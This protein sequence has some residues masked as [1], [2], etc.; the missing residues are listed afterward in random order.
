M[1]DDPHEVATLMRE[2]AAHLPIPARAT[3]ALV[4][5]LAKSEAKLPATRKVQIEKVMYLGDEGGIACA[6]TLPGQADSAVVVSLTHLRVTNPHPLAGM[7]RT[8]QINRTRFL[9]QG[10]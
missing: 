9:A 7:I 1:I 3:K 10:G 6:L 8:Y 4:R 2:M 5:E